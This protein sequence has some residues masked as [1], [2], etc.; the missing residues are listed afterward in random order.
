MTIRCTPTVLVSLLAAA[1]LASCASSPDPVG[2][3]PHVVAA[4]PGETLVFSYPGDLP[5]WV[6]EPGVDDDT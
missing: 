6:Y 5:Q 3:N 4:D 1:G 2:E